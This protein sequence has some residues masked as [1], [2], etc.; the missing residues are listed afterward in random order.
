M[1]FSQAIAKLLRMELVQQVIHSINT[2]IGCTIYWMIPQVVSIISSNFR[3]S[4][5][6]FSFSFSSL[7]GDLSFFTQD[8]ACSSSFFINQSINLI[9][10][11]S[12]SSYYLISPG[13]T[14]V[15]S[16]SVFSRQFMSLTCSFNRISSS[17]SSFSQIL[18]FFSSLSS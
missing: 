18:L 10:M 16:S 11:I 6:F 15:C 4:N 3:L 17:I 8:F 2:T 12:S 14:L 7:L 13:S 5:Q 1:Q 9:L